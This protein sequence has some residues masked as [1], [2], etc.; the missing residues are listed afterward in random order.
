[1]LLGVSAPQGKRFECFAILNCGNDS[2]QNI[3][4]MIE[5]FHSLTPAAERRRAR[6]SPESL[7]DLI[8]NQ[9]LMHKEQEL[10]VPAGE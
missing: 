10:R 8:Q 6:H 3:A 4:M 7:N 1:M 9:A 5:G 2:T